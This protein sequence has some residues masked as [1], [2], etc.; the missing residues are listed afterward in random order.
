MNLPMAH[1]EIGMDFVVILGTEPNSKNSK[2]SSR[3]YLLSLL[4]NITNNNNNIMMSEYVPLKANM[5]KRPP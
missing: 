3:R 4:R 5:D 2:S 1:L